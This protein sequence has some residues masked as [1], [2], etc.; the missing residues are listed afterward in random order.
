MFG[1]SLTGSIGE[2]ALFFLYGLGQNGKSVFLIVT[3]TVVGDYHRE[4]PIEIFTETKTDRRGAGGEKGERGLPGPR[5]DPGTSGATIVGWK[6]DPERYVAMPVMSDG[7]D[8]PP[9]DLRG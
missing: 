5:G 3:S 9:L 1:Y 2:H 7:S 6:I 4:A 8:G